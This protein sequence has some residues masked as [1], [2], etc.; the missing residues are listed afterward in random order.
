MSG[1]GAL[2]AAPADIA[3]REGFANWMRY[4][5]VARQLSAEQL[6]RRVGQISHSYIEAI[7]L[8]G[9][10]TDKVPADLLQRIERVL[11]PLPIALRPADYSSLSLSPAPVDGLVE[12]STGAAPA[13]SPEAMAAGAT[14]AVTIAAHPEGWKVHLGL[15]IGFG[16][17]IILTMPPADATALAND[18]LKHAELA[19]L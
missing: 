3:Q 1:E 15:K 7:E 4:Q 14:H 5:R 9:Y 18:L 16:D 6:A 12:P 17:E 13:A 10:A 8:S 2:A 19:S 11:G